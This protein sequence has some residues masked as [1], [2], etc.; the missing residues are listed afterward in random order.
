MAGNTDALL[1]GVDGSAATPG[2]D[3]VV[4]DAMANARLAG[5]VF[6]DTP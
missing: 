2:T 6:L 1:V 3:D 5:L 4:R